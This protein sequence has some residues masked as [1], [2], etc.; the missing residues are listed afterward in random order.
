MK[1]ALIS[2]EECL[3]DPYEICSGHKCARGTF[4]KH[5]LGYSYG[6]ADGWCMDT[7]IPLTLSLSMCVCVCIA[8]KLATPLV[9]VPAS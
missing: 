8:K 2:K 3:E 5:G 9:N 4:E 6:W 7:C 1:G